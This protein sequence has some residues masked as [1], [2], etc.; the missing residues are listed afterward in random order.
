MKC[1]PH[2]LTVSHRPT[3]QCRFI[4][5]DEFCEIFAQC[6]GLPSP[7]CAPFVGQWIGSE[8]QQRRA[9]EHGNVVSAHNIVPGAG[10]TI[11]HDQ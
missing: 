2:Q 9:D 10:H 3:R 5:D 7:C 1:R 4:P 11:A 8:G 6:L